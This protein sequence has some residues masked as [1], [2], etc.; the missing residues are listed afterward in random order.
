MKKLILTVSIFGSS[1][2]LATNVVFAQTPSDTPTSVPPPPTVIPS[3]TPTLSPLPYICTW[4][5]NNNDNFFCADPSQSSD[6]LTQGRQL[7]LCQ[8]SLDESQY[9]Q[10][11]N[12]QLQIKTRGTEGQLCNLFTWCAP[13]VDCLKFPQVSYDPPGCQAIGMG[14]GW[15]PDECTTCT[16][17]QVNWNFADRSVSISNM[18]AQNDRPLVLLEGGDT[19][20]EYPDTTVDY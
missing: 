12:W 5:R 18:Q 1:V 2:L 14:V 15:N 3:P 17:G 4:P 6:A 13:G 11:G 9:N 20:I 19:H 10:A 16:Q 8:M 7:G